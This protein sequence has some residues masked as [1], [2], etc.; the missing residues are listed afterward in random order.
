M[1]LFELFVKVGVDDQA[2]AK[3]SGI[4]EK[5]GKG[6][7]TAA[8]VGTA[9][10][11]TAATGIAALTTESIKHYAE[12][13]QLVGGVETLFE[14]SANKVKQYAAEA[15]RSAGLSAN[16]YMSTVTGFS[17]SLLQSLGKGAQTDLDALKENLDE[18][19]DLTKKSW[20][21]RIALAKK[22]KKNNVA[23][24]EAQMDA[25]LK[26]LKKGNEQRLAEAE[27]ANNKSVVTAETQALA[28]DLA[29]Q[30]VI[31]MAD[32]AAKMGTSMELIQNAYAGFSKQN[33]TMLD[34]LKLGYGGTGEE[35]KRLI[36]DAAAL[37]DV[38]KE[39]GVSVDA[40]DMSFANI[41]KAITVVQTK[42]G[43][44]GTTAAEAGRTIEGSIGAMKASW[45]NLLTGM[46]NSDADLE[47]LISELVTTIV[48]DGT[49]SNL[50][51]LGNVLPAVETA[52]AGVGT[53]L[54]DGLPKIVEQLPSIIGTALPIVVSAA[55]NLLSS[56]VNVIPNLLSTLF[57][58]AVPE[59]LS[60]IESLAQNILAVLPN[61]LELILGSILPTLLPMVIDTAVSLVQS[62]VDVLPTIIEKLYAA[63]PELYKSIGKSLEKNLPILVKAVMD[64]LVSV[65]KILPN[66]M[67]MV[68]DIMPEFYGALI[69]ALIDSVPELLAGL[70]E[71]FVVLFKNLPQLIKALLL[72]NTI[73]MTVMA[74]YGFVQKFIERGL[75]D[76]IKEFATN[77]LENVFSWLKGFATTPLGKFLKFFTDMY[78]SRLK[79][80]SDI[81]KFIVE[82]LKNGIQSAWNNLR[83]WFSGLFD[84]LISVA[85]K[86][87][88]IKSPS[89]VFK[90]IGAFTAEGFGEGFNKAFG[91][92]EK[93]IESALD[94]NGTT[95]GVNA[96]GS[97]SGGGALGGIGGTSFGTVNIN[98]EGYNAQ[99]DDELAEMI[100]EKLQVMTERKGAVFA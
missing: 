88:G 83:E 70:G 33:Y 2:S 73:G 17:A 47:K 29:N 23:E 49:E 34:N 100:A 68:A 80:F 66:A 63:L 92:V 76:K 89:R 20:S 32:N 52:L 55:E 19:Y 4:S 5:V 16:D 30:A 82:G 42:M 11:A 97:Y 53:L 58:T 60:G 43:I 50:G 69:F 18:Q 61:V 22:M 74:I 65:L 59:L 95:F 77:A 67:L 72:G 86:I 14:D 85:K 24:L 12:Y 39:L 38:Q 90:K 25:E 37:T 15:Y 48:G 98:I 31:D 21:D 35:M 93:D 13:E 64:L 36:K 56:V 9:A 8:K 46:A 6:L 94:F 87:L 84:D 26:A 81:G 96:Y 10:I 57:E 41:V 91:D 44:T 79:M 1:N 78:M 7:A 75:A 62:I 51:V 71:F 45:E 3:L 99:D 28:A 40:T 54:R 27:A